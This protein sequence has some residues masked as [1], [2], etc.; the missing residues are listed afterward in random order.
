MSIKYEISLWRDYLA[1]DQIDLSKQ[2]PGSGVT[3]VTSASELKQGNIY[4]IWDRGTDLE[5]KQNK[6]LSNK[7]HYP[8]T[9]REK[10]ILEASKS[11]Q[12]DKLTVNDYMYYFYDSKGEEWSINS[13]FTIDDKGNRNY[14]IAK[15]NQIIKEE[16]V[17]ILASD[18][19]VSNLGKI[20]NIHFIKNID[21]S[22]TLKFEI[23]GVYNA[24]GNGETIKN[25]FLNLIHLKSKIKLKYNKKWYT[26]IVNS[27]EEKKSSKGITYQ[28]SADDLA[29]EELSKNGYSLNFTDDAETIELSGAGTAK[30]LAQRVLEGTDWYY[31]ENFSD[32]NFREFK[33]ESIYDAFQGKY[34]D[35]KIPM[36]A[37]RMHYSPYLRKFV[38]KTSMIYDNKPIYYT[39][40]DET[41]CSGSARNLISTNSE[42]T[43]YP[44]WEPQHVL[45]NQRRV[46]N[47][48]IS[49][50]DLNISSGKTQKITIDLKKEN[51]KSELYVLRII[52]PSNREY[53]PAIIKGDKTY[54]SAQNKCYFNNFYAIYL[55]N[56]VS[57][58]KLSLQFFT[59]DTIVIKKIELF[60]LELINESTN[61]AIG[62]SSTTLG[63]SAPKA[64]EVS[65]FYANANNFKTFKDSN[66]KQ[67]TGFKLVH[68]DSTISAT[69]FGK[70][71]FFTEPDESAI[72]PINDQDRINSV[73]T[74]PNNV[75]NDK[76]KNKLN[77]KTQCKDFK[78][79]IS[80]EINYDHYQTYLDENY[81][82]QNNQDNYIKITNNYNESDYY[83][84][85][86]INYNGE[87][88]YKWVN[89]AYELSDE[90]VRIITANRSNRYTILQ[91]IAEQFEVFLGFK[92]LHNPE[93]GEIIYNDS[94]PQKFVYFTDR[95]GKMKYSGF[96]EG[97]NLESISRKTIGKDIVSKMY[98][99]YK[100]NSAAEEGIVDISL[101]PSNP[102]GEKYI[103]NFNHFLN[104][105]ALD[106]SFELEFK[107][108]KKTLKQ[109][110]NKLFSLQNKYL[111]IMDN[112]RHDKSA[113]DTIVYEIGA[114]LDEREKLKTE[115]LTQTNKFKFDDLKRRNE[116]VC[117][118]VL[119][120]K[121][122]ADKK[123][124]QGGTIIW[125]TK[126]NLKS[127]GTVEDLKKDS[128]KYEE[129]Y[130]KYPKKWYPLCEDTKETSINRKSNYIAAQKT[131]SSQQKRAVGY[132][133][134]GKSNKRAREVYNSNSFNSK[135][136]DKTFNSIMVLEEFQYKENDKT[137]TGIV[138]IDRDEAHLQSTKKGYATAYNK[139]IDN[140]K[141][142]SSKNLTKGNKYYTGEFI[143]NNFRWY[144]DDNLDKYC[145]YYH[146]TINGKSS[147]EIHLLVID[148]PFYIK[149]ITKQEFE[150]QLSV[151]NLEVTPLPCIY[152]RV[153]KPTFNARK[154][155]YLMT[156]TTEKDL[157]NKKEKLE[158]IVEQDEKQYKDLTKQI[159]ILLKGKKNYIDAFES[160]YCNYI[161]EG[162]WSGNNKTY[163]NNDSYYYDA[164]VAS[165]NSSIPKAEYTLNVLDLSSLPE[166]KDYNFDVGD[167]TFVM[168]RD[169]FGFDPNGT[170]A[171]ERVAITNLDIALDNPK[172]NKI[173]I[174][175]Y[176]NRFED[177]FTRISATLTSVE[178][179]QDSW[180]KANILNQ[181]GTIN[182]SLLTGINTANAN[183]VSE[184]LGIINTYTLD[185]AGLH[186]SDP[187][188]KHQIR[189]T[190][191]GL[192]FTNTGDSN[193]EWT[194]GMDANGINAN[195]I[196]SGQLKTNKI[197]ILSDYTAAFVLDSLGMT[198]YNSLGSTEMET[199]K[200][201]TFVRM[202]K[203]GLY[204]INNNL[205][206]GTDSDGVPW[207]YN[208]NDTQALENIRDK[209]KV[210][211]TR[212][213]FT[214][215][216]KVGKED[217]GGYI[218]IGNLDYD[219][220]GISYKYDGETIF[221]VNNKGTA[222][223]AGFRFSGKKMWK[224]FDRNKKSPY[225]TKDELESIIK[226][227]T[228]RG[229]GSATLNTA[230]YG[231]ILNEK[232]YPFYLGPDGIGMAGIKIDAKNGNITIGRPQDSY[233]EDKAALTI[234][235]G[236]INGNVVIK[237]AMLGPLFVYKGKKDT[238]ANEY[239]YTE[240]DGKNAR[241]FMKVNNFSPYREGK[242]KTG[243]ANL[244]ARE[245]KFYLGE[246]LINRSILADVKM[247]SST[248]E[249]MK[250]N[251][252]IL[253]SVGNGFWVHSSGYG[254]AGG[255]FYFN[256][257]LYAENI[258]AGHIKVQG[259]NIDEYIKTHGP[260]I[261]DSVNN[262][263]EKG[264]II[265]GTDG[266][267]G[268]N[269]LGIKV[270]K[271]GTVYIKNNAGQWI[272][273]QTFSNN[274]YP[275]I[276]FKNIN[277]ESWLVMSIKSG[278]ERGA[279]FC[280]DLI[281]RR[282]LKS[283]SWG[284]LKRDNITMIYNGD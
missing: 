251:N 35:K 105:G 136:L 27:K 185:S 216:S 6:K 162:Y 63:R 12:K 142:I 80:S 221:E 165:N 9:Y 98:V 89:L 191:M 281:T 264:D 241:N 78:E 22:R 177:L 26:F 230:Y 157:K 7:W 181:D 205:E 1:N 258:D 240:Y 223:I 179:N 128:K 62:I 68:I 213:G 69:T 74:V 188:G 30:E 192:A 83:V 119:Y 124:R 206:F 171:L 198:A 226:H 138:I 121:K 161:K 28:V 107:N 110:N 112:Y 239:L 155:S 77:G 79:I 236:I 71:R 267:N 134:F 201:D 101:S 82:P 120:N 137:Y 67:P 257:T 253:L 237:K 169:V 180:N 53:K 231:R 51:L 167:E 153:T 115:L 247:N 212:E 175:N 183:I 97:I 114:L 199:V 190:S 4:Y 197:S 47:E 274:Y 14:R 46:D 34:V 96:K 255:N 40:E 149:N 152:P 187:S 160:K 75:I 17:C 8:M 154:E 159:Q 215:K 172:N 244:L 90:K 252:G 24:L 60:K 227:K 254:Y 284:K 279:T 156:F 276:K 103:L 242:Y 246:F 45:S 92:I 31:N 73:K 259:V 218:Q 151:K 29:L 277:S 23:P 116:E 99:E 224:D 118:W 13:L 265:L 217:E 249:G 269:G 193:T 145:L 234:Y 130:D 58:P 261:V 222:K 100:D 220:E 256:G 238:Y 250:E 2:N 70:K 268:K 211:I 76:L 203:Y 64:G 5:E 209:A 19:M 52:G 207:Y 20:N 272:I 132:P 270:Q 200:M 3:M 127:Y 273:D 84:V 18:S 248:F 93:T 66:L 146:P 86:S 55:D 228:V 144:Y 266:K 139:L 109:Y 214:Y 88:Y 33:T 42:F 245:N 122:F 25:N 126:S 113:Y 219:L 150:K 210:S 282:K 41:Y 81:N 21:G 178:M 158:K 102:T 43:S 164:L 170:P 94:K 108:Y 176:T 48:G 262:S 184:G 166:F 61:E 163:I 208:I 135:V 189:L 49:H 271:F 243:R 260:D 57:S 280:L 275:S 233:S 168:D 174:K 147:Q 263:I 141:F 129:H 194:V 196:Q 15:S 54:C 36:I 140:R 56:N 232:T 204:L 143:Q 186:I 32:A 44:D 65:I 202:D 195:A 111:K 123:N 235:N 173:T 50:Y 91:D 72:I 85:K 117:G 125:E 59:N 182:S 104:T 95:L 16:K 106:K 11:K 278:G 133:F 229:T 87:I 10:K 38:T 37:Y 225:L 283:G 148:G 39:I 131:G